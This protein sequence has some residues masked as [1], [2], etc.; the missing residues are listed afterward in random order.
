MRFASFWLGDHVT[1]L[2]ATYGL[3]QDCFGWKKIGI[4]KEGEEGGREE[5]RTGGR[6]RGGKDRRK[7]EEGEGGRTGEGREKEGGREQGE[8]NVGRLSRRL[9]SSDIFPQ[10]QPFL[11]L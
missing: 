8:I 7:G 11:Y 9:E 3:P 5:G 6:E 10:S 2:S 1:S 4:G